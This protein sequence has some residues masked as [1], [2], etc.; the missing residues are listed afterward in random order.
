M[1]MGV[2]ECPETVLSSLEELLI[3]ELDKTESSLLL[4]NKK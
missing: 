3:G 1:I 4:K 2:E